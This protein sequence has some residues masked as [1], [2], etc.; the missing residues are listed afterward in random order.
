MDKQKR[1][2]LNSLSAGRFF[3]EVCC[4]GLL[5]SFARLVALGV[6]VERLDLLAQR[7]AV[8]A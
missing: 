7:I 1:P 2:A 4:R 3:Y 6:N 8:D 5:L